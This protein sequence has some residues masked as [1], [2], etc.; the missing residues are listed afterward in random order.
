MIVLVDGEMERKLWILD[1]A[2][3]IEQLK[4]E[5]RLKVIQVLF[6]LF[7]SF[8]VKISS[9]CSSSTVNKY[10]KWVRGAIPMRMIGQECIQNSNNN[11][12]S[13]SMIITKTETEIQIELICEWEQDQD[14]GQ[15]LAKHFTLQLIQNNHCTC[16]AE[17]Y[18]FSQNMQKMLL[19]W[20]SSQTI[21]L[22][23]MAPLIHCL[24]KKLSKR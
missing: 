18:S 14:W 7:S 15:Y 5:E 9:F 3:S 16:W 4:N 19:F 12:S 6:F 24:D 22:S 17:I 13:T 1:R 21:I 8:P 10:D 2:G 20:M 11:F 23:G